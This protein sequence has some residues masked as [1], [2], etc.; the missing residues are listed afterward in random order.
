MNRSK[1][2]ISLGLILFL[3]G[4]LTGLAIPAMSSPRLGLSGHLEAVMNGMFLILVGLFWDKLT[5]SKKSSK[6]TF[7]ALIFGTYTNWI[8]VTLAAVWGA[9]GKM[10]PIAGGKLQ[11][12]MVQEGLIKFGLISLSLA[13]IYSTIMMIIG[14][15]KQTSSS[16]IV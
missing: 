16:K 4:L 1:N 2:L 14:L 7:V 3:L 15:K 10:M 5:L 6:L 13:M 12:S 11:G 8:T 9:G